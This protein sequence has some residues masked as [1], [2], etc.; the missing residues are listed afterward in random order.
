MRKRHSAVYGNDM[1]PHQPTMIWLMVKL[2]IMEKGLQ[3]YP[4]FEKLWRSPFKNTPICAESMDHASYK[5][6]HCF[7]MEMQTIMGS[8]FGSHMLIWSENSLGVNLLLNNYEAI[9]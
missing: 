2:T 6:M 7:S 4:P 8:T 1:T 5:E 3:Q 9:P